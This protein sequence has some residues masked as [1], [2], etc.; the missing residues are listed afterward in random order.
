[1]CTDAKKPK[2]AKTPALGCVGTS[3]QGGTA[4]EE[5]EGG[6]AG[7]AGLSEEEGENPLDSSLEEPEAPEGSPLPARPAAVDRSGER[8]SHFASN[9]VTSSPTTSHFSFPSST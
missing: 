2:S 5:K 6:G 1:M 8:G 7:A 4:G 3:P 9:L